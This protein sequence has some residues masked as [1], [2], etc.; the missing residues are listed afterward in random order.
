MKYDI[1]VVHC[2]AECAGAG[3]VH[4]D[5]LVECC[6]VA[7]PIKELLSVELCLHGGRCLS[8]PHGNVERLLFPILEE[9]RKDG[10]GVF[11]IVGRQSVDP[12]ESM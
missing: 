12:G 11:G 8:A 5:V 3:E 9:T 10:G 6:V 7:C 4:D 1:A 2:E